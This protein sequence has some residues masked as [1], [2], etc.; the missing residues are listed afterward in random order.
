MPWASHF[1]LRQRCASLAITALTTICLY[2]LQL[3]SQTHRTSKTE[4]T[5]SLFAPALGPPAGSIKN[6]VTFGDSFSDVN[7]YSNGSPLL[8]PQYAAAYGN[9]SLHPYA[10][11]SAVCSEKL[12]P[13]STRGPGILEDELPAYFN[14]T[15]SGLYLDPDSTIYTLWI[16]TNDLG[17]EGLLVGLNPP[18]TTI[19]D[20][21]RCPLDWIKAIYDVGGRNFIIQNA[22]PLQYS[23]QY[24]ADGYLNGYWLIPHNTTEWN[25]AI[26]QSI[27]AYN[28]LVSLYLQ[29]LAHTELPGA[30]IGLFS[31]YGL[32]ED[33]HDHPQKYLNGTAPFNVTGCVH[34]CPVGVDCTTAEGTERDS[35]MWYDEVHPS[36][37]THRVIAK[38]LSDAITRKSEQW[39]NWLS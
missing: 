5:A 22:A 35:F 27:A 8:W 19:V 37:Q 30:H 10:K 1:L 26:K 29:N 33:I 15:A 24:Q 13:R 11:N 3:I 23:V 6:L 14:D 4:Y 16:G 18:N 9:F 21:S 38:I 36:E 32:F 31:S 28:E 7:S 39:I 12:T 2:R 20:V 34:S 17:P 25:I